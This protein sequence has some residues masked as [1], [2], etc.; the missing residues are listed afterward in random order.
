MQLFT[1]TGRETLNTSPDYSQPVLHGSDRYLLMYDIGEKRYSIYNSFVCVHHEETDYPIFTGAMSNSGYYAVVTESYEH[2]G[3]V[4]LYN[5]RFELINRYNRT[6][7]V[8]CVDINANGNRIAFATV[9][10]REGQYVTTLVIA[11]PGQEQVNAEMLFEGM[12]A[13]RVT[14]IDQQRLLLICDQ[15]SYI[16]SV[17]DGTIIGQI[18]N[19]EL[20]LC[21]ADCNDTLVAFVFS[22]NPVTDS[23]RMI[24][25]DKNGGLILDNTFQAGISQM[26]VND[27]Y[28]FLLTDTGIIRFDPRT[29]SYQQIDCDTSG[30]TLL[31]RSQD[32]V[33]LCGAQSAVYYPF[34]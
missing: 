6:N 20:Q 1:A 15:A 5:D 27:N 32:E 33:L 2:A 14:F 30:Q 4:S 22:V 26:Q 3:V 23:Y 17:D 12:F 10:M 25:T 19:G 9:G 16:I 13:Y 29:L 21:Y 28:V 11:I 7:M 8:T 24:I 31:I 18:A 34:D